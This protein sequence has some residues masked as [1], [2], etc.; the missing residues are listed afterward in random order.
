[1]D[2]PQ[3]TRFINGGVIWVPVCLVP[4]EGPRVKAR[5]CSASCRHRGICN[6]GTPWDTSD[7]SKAFSSSEPELKI[8]AYLAKQPGV[9]L[10]EMGPVCVGS[11]PG[12]LEPVLDG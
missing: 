5:P 3:A 8:R 6:H 10:Q 1:M 12:I 4:K 11:N 7:K 9:V 2:S